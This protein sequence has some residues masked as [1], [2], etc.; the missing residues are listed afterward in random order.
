M[1]LFF[2]PL[3]RMMK[4]QKKL[5][6]GSTDFL[7]NLLENSVSV[8]VTVSVMPSCLLYLIYF[9]QSFMFPGDVQK[10]APFSYET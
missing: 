1:T 4:Y 7:K 6:R 2:F 10:M 9:I 3:K 5:C 8:L